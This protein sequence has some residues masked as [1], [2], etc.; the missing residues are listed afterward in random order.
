MKQLE[1]KAL[2]YYI[3]LAFILFV[4]VCTKKDLC[5][6]E[7][8]SYGLSNTQLEMYAEEG[9]KYEPASAPYMEY[10]SV[11]S[12]D[13]FNYAKVWSNQ[14]LDTHPP[15]YYAILHTICSMF[16]ERYSIWF[17]EIINIVAALFILFFVRKIIILF[18]DDKRIHFFLTIGYVFSSGM[19]AQI[20]YIRMYVLA[21]LWI[22]M[23]TYYCLRIGAR[24]LEKNQWDFLKLSIVIYV[25]AMTHYYCIIYAILIVGCL[26]ICLLC[27]RDWKSVLPVILGSIGSAV[28]SIITFPAMINHLFGGK[29]GSDD[30]NKLIQLDWV[31]I[32]R[33]LAFYWDCVDYSIFG[34]LFWIFA[35]IVIVCCIRI[36]WKWHT[37]EH[38]F[39]AG[40]IIL[41]VPSIVFF[42]LV[43]ISSTY[44][45][46]RY[47]APVFAI[48]FIWTTYG[49][50]CLC[51][52]AFNKQIALYIFLV[53]LG[54]TTCSG[55]LIKDNSKWE[56]LCRFS[57][58]QLMENVSKHTEDDCFVLFYDEIPSRNF[59]EVSSY[60]SVTFISLDNEEMLREIM[61]SY[62]GGCVV[63]VPN[64]EDIEKVAKLVGKTHIEKLGER[65]IKTFYIY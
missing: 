42:L 11:S 55:W 61:G 62:Q 57:T 39:D 1:W 10:V 63:C 59:Y 15:F 12:T 33:R 13:R 9:V 23:M 28:F 65:I 8:F 56:Y 20:P 32:R 24:K 25:G 26:G 5:V 18:T 35:L 50:Y 30:L 64:D 19:L 31:D 53:Y 45:M 22:T 14:A 52:K 21:N 49:I 36:V 7:L 2:S 34:S 47:V 16:P 40:W 60:K 51:K 3:I 6:D 58:R 4:L 48:M 29:H 37:G 46:V 54:T 41:I 43:S 44:L 38:E 17:G 27:K